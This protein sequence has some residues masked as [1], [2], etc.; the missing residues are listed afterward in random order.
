[1]P[2]LEAAP[3]RETP[4][5][6]E[7]A[8]LR[9][10]GRGGLEDDEQLGRVARLDLAA[11]ELIETWSA[12]LRR[13]PGHSRTIDVLQRP[14]PGSDSG[15][16][17][18]EELEELI[19]R[20]ALEAEPAEVGAQEGVP[21][22]A[23]HRL[24]QLAQQQVSLLVRDR[25]VGFV[26]IDPAQIGAQAGELRA[27][28]EALQRY[29]KVVPPGRGV[30]LRRFA[31]LE[32]L[33][34]PPLGIDGETLV[35][36]EV[37]RVRVGDEIARPG[38]RSLVRDH[39]HQRSVA[40]EDRRGDEGEPRVLHAAIGK[41]RRHHQDVVAVPL[42]GTE[43]LL[44]RADHLLGLGELVRRRI[45]DRALRP[46]GRP[47]RQLAPLQVADRERE[48]VGRDRLG[49]LE[50][51]HRFAAAG[52]L[53]AL[54]GRGHQRA[55]PRRHLEPGAAHRDP[56]ARRVLQRRK[57]T[58]VDGLALREQEWLLAR[59][60]RRLEPLQRARGGRSAVPD[61]QATR[62][63]RER[64]A[65]ARPEDGLGRREL[66]AQRSAVE[67]RHCVDSQLPGIEVDRAAAGLAEAQ[68]DLAFEH[69]M[70]EVGAQRQ[71]D[72]ARLRL[73]AVCVAM[74]IEAHA[75]HLACAL[76]RRGLIGTPAVAPS[77][78]PARVREPMDQPDHLAGIRDQPARV[79]TRPRRSTDVNGDGAPP[80]ED[81]ERFLVRLAGADVDRE[82]PAHAGEQPEDR[83]P[84]RGSR[85]HR[86]E[87][88]VC[89]AQLELLGRHQ[90]AE[91]LGGGDPRR[92]FRVPEVQHER[93]GPILD[94]DTR[95]LQ[96]R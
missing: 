90:L 15:K 30:K 8:Q 12:R 14:R 42:V 52:I 91:L 38:V 63:C 40:D 73:I 89:I 21:G 88:I 80:V 41:A 67:C 85:R 35:E 31:A 23:P 43:Q 79:R 27:G 84:H 94:G 29:L 70:L 36:P 45:H 71:V 11:A 37:V 81:L 95:R 69:S 33:E 5:G 44:R 76:A 22:G 87:G 92:R 61:A 72:V 74:R 24:L 47:R 4:P 17:G 1:M 86:F 9:R 59:G 46:D 64:D 10:V 68:R 32:R 75:E 53:A 25:G 18:L 51:V 6:V 96:D 28:R 93:P 48:Q 13:I 56:D 16:L 60:L 19:R 2:Q 26:R 66:V 83:A 58:G 55:Q 77:G 62:T 65:Q 78:A 50:E 34:D 7:L 54:G 82:R 49:H 57:R 20:D 3:L 39:A